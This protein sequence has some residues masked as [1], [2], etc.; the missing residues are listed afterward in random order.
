MGLVVAGIDGGGLERPA[1]APRVDP[2]SA[3]AFDL[4]SGR[5]NRA[6]SVSPPWPAKV[7]FRVRIAVPF[8]G[9]GRVIAR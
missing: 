9:R 5:S 2:H 6:A 1:L 4:P 3:T 8:S 7:I